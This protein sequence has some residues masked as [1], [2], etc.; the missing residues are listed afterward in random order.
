MFV[1]VIGDTPAQARQAEIRGVASATPLQSV[2]GCLADV[3][4]GGKVRLA[5][6]QRDDIIHRLHDFK[7]VANA[8]AGN[9]TDVVCDG[10][11]HG[12]TERR[13]ELASKV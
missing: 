10:D 6:A 7:K 3:P 9:V 5:D 11:A 4:W 12:V 8:R 2:N 13:S 1:D